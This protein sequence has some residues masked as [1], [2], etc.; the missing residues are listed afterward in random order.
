MVYAFE[1][2]GLLFALIMIYL[3]YLEY[4]RKEFQ[5]SLFVFGVQFG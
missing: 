1:I 5:S 3:T 2:I 4:K